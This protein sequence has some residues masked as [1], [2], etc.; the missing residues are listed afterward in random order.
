M[1]V[2][3]RAPSSTNCASHARG[4]LLTFK[5]GGDKQYSVRP[6]RVRDV[7]V[8]GTFSRVPAAPF[9]IAVGPVGAGM[10]GKEKSIRLLGQG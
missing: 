6:F 1:A 9:A 2:T 5:N 10:S 8:W 7:F 4:S 3:F